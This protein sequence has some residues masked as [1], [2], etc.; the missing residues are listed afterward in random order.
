MAMV[1]SA[2][3]A[4]VPA[5][6]AVPCFSVKFVPLSGVIATLKAA[7]SLA[8]SATPVAPLVGEV[9]T[10]VGAAVPAGATVVN[11]HDWSAAKLPPAADFVPAVMVAV[12]PW[13]A[14]SALAG[15]K[16]AVVPS[17]LV[18]TVPATAVVPCFSVK[19]VAVSGAIARSKTTD[20]LVVSATLAAA[21]KGVV[22][23]IFGVGAGVAGVLLPQAIA[24]SVTRMI[25]SGVDR[26][27]RAD[28]W[29]GF[30]MNE[31]IDLL[32]IKLNG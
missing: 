24:A 11:F 9:A 3:F 21:S 4:T 12:K 16:V 23:L 5:T 2:L 22:E 10:S 31:R 14:A 13:P 18:A 29:C 6:A 25:A 19:F 8:L 28:E 15:V 7:E 20:G 26:L 17:V 27:L 30:A 32:R 1:P